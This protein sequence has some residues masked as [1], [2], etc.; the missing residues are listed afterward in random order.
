[1]T[2]KLWLFSIIALLS[3]T[4]PLSF[5]QHHGGE[6]APPTSFGEGEVT[7]STI[8]SPYDFTPAKYSE[9]NLKI[10]FFDPRTDINIQSVT[11]R[12]QIFYGAQLVANQMFFDNDGELEIKIKPKS[13]CQQKDL[14]KCTK[15]YGD[16]DP[17]VPNALSSKSSSI[18]VISGP[19]FIDAGQYIVKTDIIGAKSPK[20]QTT[21]DIH[22]ET[23][24]MIPSEQKFMITASGVPYSISTKNFNNL[25]TE[26]HYDES[27][28][29][30]MFQIPFNWEHVGHT[31]SLKN[32]IEIPK[33][34]LPFQNTGSFYGKV[35][36]VLIFPKDL[37]FDKYSSKNSNILFFMINNDELKQIRNSDSKINI[38]I[39]PTPQST[40]ASE[41][42]LFDNGFKAHT[43]YDSRYSKSKDFIFSIVFFDPKGNLATDVRY[44]YGLKNP[45]GK[46]ITNI[47]SNNLGIVLPSGID[48]RIFPAP[49]AG[50]YLMQIG[51]LGIGSDTF[52]KPLFTKF[53]LEIITSD[54][55]KTDL[56]KTDLVKT[57]A[58]KIAISKSIIPK[59]IKNI[60]GWWA[61]GSIDDNSFI[62]GIQFLIKEKLLNIPSTERSGIVSNEI[63]KWIK[64]TAGW[65]A[66]GKINDTEFIQG[67]QFLI[68]EGMIKP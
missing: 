42:I 12:V 47:G 9:A 67:I 53:K 64:N 21:K 45:S 57:E 41:E 48:T 14:W 22:F 58:P 35:N 39:T 32:Y 16:V 20:T 37:H 5:A 23:T 61:D 26:L 28:Q 46:E 49:I 18:P 52:E 44:G 25:I 31:D 51:L 66:D 15:Y 33:N 13:E 30:I 68:K 60:A 63:P 29:S 34:F 40:I 10:R 8:L 36:D 55:V 2:S 50:T 6:Q 27:S 43:S 24:V 62:Q 54:Q 1:M 19:V 11:F 3:I 65:W 17:I 38:V 56:V 7:V 59:W 4:F